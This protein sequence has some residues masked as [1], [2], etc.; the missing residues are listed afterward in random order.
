ME[1]EAVG[2]HATIEIVVAILKS[3]VRFHVGDVS[4]F[5]RLLEDGV[6]ECIWLR[7]I[8]GRWVLSL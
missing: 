4:L 8:G 6:V 5:V 7:R 2:A 3:H 1:L